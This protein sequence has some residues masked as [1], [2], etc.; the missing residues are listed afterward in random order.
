M[1]KLAL[2]FFRENNINISQSDINLI[3]NRSNGDRGILKNELNK[4]KLFLINKKKISTDDIMKLTNLTENHSINE[5]IN[6]CL[7]RN[8]KNIKY[9]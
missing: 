3:T 5:L 1:S 7:A 9:F 6:N 2:L 4:I 8:A